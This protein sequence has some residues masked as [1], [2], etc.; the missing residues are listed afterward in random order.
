MSAPSREIGIVYGG[1]TVA[2]TDDV[3]IGVDGPDL[4]SIRFD[5]E[6]AHS[7]PSTFAT[8]KAAAETAFRTPRQG[9]VI[10]VR[11]TTWKSFSHSGGTGFNANPKIES[12]RRGRSANSIIYTISID[13]GRPADVHG[14]NYRRNSTVRVTWSTDRR[15]HVDVDGVY[16]V[17][18]STTARQ[19]YLDAIGTYA[20]SILTALGGSF[21]LLEENV[22][23]DDQ[24]KV[25]TF[26]RR[27]DEQIGGRNHAEIVIETLPNTRKRVAISGM[28]STISA[29]T[30]S[31]AAYNTNFPAFRD[32]VLASVGGTFQTTTTKAEKNDTDLVTTFTNVYDETRD[33]R[34]D[35]SYQLVYSTDRRLS[36]FF[37]A[38]YFTG[39]SGADAYALALAD[40]ELWA[41]GVLGDIGGTYNKRNESYQP[42]DIVPPNFC[43]ARL[44]FLEAYTSQAGSLPHGSI[45]DQNY[46]VEKT[47][48]A[49]G[50]YPGANVR[51]MVEIKIDYTAQV[52]KTITT[53]LVQLWNSIISWLLSVVVPVYQT[54][55]AVVVD[56]SSMFNPDNNILRGN[57]RVWIAPGNLLL[58]KFESSDKNVSQ[59]VFDGLWTGND[60]DYH[61]YPGHRLCL[62][63]FI[64]TYR[65]LA[66]SATPLPAMDTKLQDPKVPSVGSIFGGGTGEG[67]ADPFGFGNLEGHEVSREQPRRTVHEIG[68]GNPGG[69]MVVEDISFAYTVRYVNKS[70]SFTS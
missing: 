13:F 56:Q 44:E 60:L 50:D 29:A 57:V 22:V 2:T 10:T 20:S 52:D 67:G 12:T 40:F 41:L 16:T 26:H 62:K 58:Y 53:N 9:L 33:G 51:R 27:Y 66:G 1:Y 69:K 3:H 34:Q 39:A 46:K 25:A 65:R 7:D 45:R 21:D 24:N 55:T 49:P 70:P 47:V 37:F 30:S 11:G 23:N 17:N 5:F 63:T 15:M 59:K 19:Q 61:V 38:N 68:S 35:G 36:V 48:E 8:M 14:T 31:F 64:K 43:S 6:I 54:G 42:N 32:A 18:G 4:S 28:Y